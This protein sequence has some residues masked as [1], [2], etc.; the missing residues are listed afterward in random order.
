MMSDTTR[1]VRCSLKRKSGA[2]FFGESRRIWQNRLILAVL[3]ILAAVPALTSAGTSYAQSDNPIHQ[4]LTS[5]TIYRPVQNADSTVTLRVCYEWNWPNLRASLTR[6]RSIFTY[7]VWRFAEGS[8]GDNFSTVLSRFTGSPTLV[9][10]CHDWIIPY[11]ETESRT[12]MYFFRAA[13]SDR[14]PGSPGNQLRSAP[15]ASFSE[16]IERWFRGGDEELQ[17]PT[18]LTA[19]AMTDNSISLSWT[20][21]PRADGYRYGYTTENGVDVI[22]GNPT[23]V[24][25]H[26]YTA[27]ITGLTTATGYNVFVDAWHYNEG[28]FSTLPQKDLRGSRATLA[29]GTTGF[30]TP[31]PEPEEDPSA[32]RDLTVSQYL[33]P[34]IADVAPVSVDGNSERTRIRWFSNYQANSYEVRV[35]RTSPAGLGVALMS[36]NAVIEASDPRFATEARFRR[37]GPPNRNAEDPAR[38]RGLSGFC[39]PLPAYR[40]LVC[41]FDTSF[42][43]APLDAAP[44]SGYIPPRVAGTLGRL[45][46]EPDGDSEAMQVVASFGDQLLDQFHLVLTGY[47]TDNYASASN[48]FSFNDYLIDRPPILSVRGWEFV[49]DIATATSIEEMEVAG[50]SGTPGKITH[51]IWDVESMPRI[52]N[53]PPGF[54]W[55]FTASTG[56]LT[57]TSGLEHSLDLSKGSSYQI[58]VRGVFD[59]RKTP[60]SD[61]YEYSTTRLAGDGFFLTPVAGATGGDDFGLRTTLTN[62]GLTQSDALTPDTWALGISVLISFGAGAVVFVRTR[63][64]LSGMAPLASLQV[65]LIAWLF[66]SSTIAQAPLAWSVTPGFLLAA[67]GVLSF[68]RRVR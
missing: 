24:P 57:E 27:T 30:P 13:Y 52:G 65:V 51:V 50:I 58:Y 16:R 66:T 20:G 42:G 7:G 2:C 37:A 12:I 1:R 56:S 62:L 47:L 45:T 43:P 38:Y 34:R 22:S 17:S 41:P 40:D 44:R 18:A 5:I 23:L 54:D 63:G 49:I 8:T 14:N 10:D 4:A 33:A 32:R 48:D 29:T 9:T 35:V 61:V 60:W 67:L 11:N 68:I 28:F 6:G 19:T 39:S 26:S 64:D 25:G 55:E 31:T 21:H 59:D 53:N 3:L 15:Q 36:S 46:N